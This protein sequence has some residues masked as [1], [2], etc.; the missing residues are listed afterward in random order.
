MSKHKK[1]ETSKQPRRR[2][3]EKSQEGNK[4]IASDQRAGK[5][6]KVKK[7]KKQ[8]SKLKQS[9]KGNIQTKIIRNQNKY[10]QHIHTQAITNGKWSKNKKELLLS[11]HLAK[12]TAS[13]NPSREATNII[14]R[15]L[16]SVSASTDG[17]GGGLDI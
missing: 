8:R 2:R 10:V 9:T 14:F 17:L 16:V 5:R 13:T 3:K 6:R 12:R 1:H 11:R 15:P 7:M 4:G